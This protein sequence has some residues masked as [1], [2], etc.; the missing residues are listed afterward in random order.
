VPSKYKDRALLILEL[1]EEASAFREQL[2]YLAELWLAVDF[3]ADLINNQ[4]RCASGLQDERL[5]LSHH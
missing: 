1:A 4:Q 3:V 2:L 5:P